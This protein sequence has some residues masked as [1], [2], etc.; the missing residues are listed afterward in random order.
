MGYYRWECIP[1]HRTYQADGSKGHL[2][3]SCV[4]EVTYRAHQRGRS[5][6]SD[7]HIRPLT[8][9]T[10]MPIT[11]T[12]TWNHLAAVVIATISLATVSQSASAQ[13]IYDSLF[14]GNQSPQ[15]AG[16]I[17]WLDSAD[18]ALRQAKQTGKP[19]I[20]YVT[21]DHCGYCRKME[22]ESWSSPRVVGSVNQQY[23]PL[24]INAS[25]QPEQAKALQVQAFPTTLLLNQEGRVATGSAG[26][27]AP[28]QLTSLLQE[29]NA[30]KQRPQ[31]VM[32]VS[33]H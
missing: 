9:Q 33:T 19:I 1:N 2:L 7:N 23:I 3:L 28:A 31:V 15:Q 25:H 8:E 21:S 14:S 24:K 32:P 12:I 20:A 5:I 13:S 26:Y 11:K 18:E 4:M 22:R 30:L 16:S 10:L 29:A 6:V 17:R 27:L